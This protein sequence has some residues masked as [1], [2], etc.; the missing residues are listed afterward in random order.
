MLAPTT[1]TACEIMAV[2]F[3]VAC[4]LSPAMELN[5]VYQYFLHQNPEIC[6]KNIAAERACKNRRG[7]K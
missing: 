5:G 3:W 6:V 1:P 4:N 7:P 2:G